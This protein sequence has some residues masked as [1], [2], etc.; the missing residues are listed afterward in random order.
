[1][2]TWLP[3]LVA[4]VAL[5]A[6]AAA[7]L[8]ASE[9]GRSAF[10]RFKSF[11]ADGD[12]ALSRG[13]LAAPGRERGSASLFLMLDA[14]GDGRLSVKEVEG[15]GGG[16]RLARF[17]AYDVNKDGYVTRREFPNFI[18]PK[19]VAALD[20]DG[21]GALALGEIR[22]SFAGWRPSA[23]EPRGERRPPKHAA[24]PAGRPAPLCWVPN[25][26]DADDWLIEF[27]VIATGGRCRTQ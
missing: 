6:A 11:D 8:P 16:G 27:P 17:E 21:D 1:M 24:A 10:A 25:F 22:G 9:T 12:R 13:E 26:G 4:T 18:D 19:L 15:R 7:Q 14:D 3:V 2:R 23:A 5:P 20:R